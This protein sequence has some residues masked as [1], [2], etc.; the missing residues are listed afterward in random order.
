MRIS[1]STRLD[2]IILVCAAYAL[3]GAMLTM[4]GW[5]LN[6]PG[7]TDWDGDGINMKPNASLA[8]LFAAAGLLLCLL[9]PGA[10]RLIRFLAAVPLCIGTLT[11]FQHL[12]GI[13]LGI[14]TLL[15]WEPHGMRA[16][17][18]PGRMGPPMSTATLLLG[19]GIAVFP[20][21]RRIRSYRLVLGCGLTVTLIS[22]IALTG[23]LF[24]ADPLFAI[25]QLTAI[26]FQAA[27]MILAMGVALVL[28]PPVGPRPLLTE[29]SATGAFVRW[30]FPLAFLIPLG[31]G[32]L[33][34]ATEAVN[35]L[36]DDFG[37]ALRTVA[38]MF[39]LIAI[40]W[41]GG[42][43]LLRKDAA[44]RRS[45]RELADFFENATIALHW[46]SAD[47]TI[48]KA[49]QAELDLTGFAHDEYIGRN[50]R[51][52]HVDSERAEHI[53]SVLGD[54]KGLC[55]YPS[56]L[57][58]KDG[59]VRDVLVDSSAYMVE[60]RFVHSRC[61]TTDVTE[62][63]AAERAQ[64]RLAAIVED[65][66]D[67]IISI[68]LEGE[69][70]SWNAGAER[71][72]GYTAAEA[73]GRT[74]DLLIPANVRGEERSILDQLRRGNRI[75]HFET[76]R[77]HKEG[78]RINVSL[79]VSPL[80]DLSGRLVGASKIARD[81]SERKQA[82]ARIMAEKERVQILADAVP[83]LIS[84][85]DLDFRHVLVN[86]AYEK[87]FRKPRIAFVGRTLREVLGDKA[88]EVIRPHVQT[89]LGGRV[90]HFESEIEFANQPP[91]WIDATY[92]P[93]LDMAG[94]VRGFVA[95][96]MDITARKRAEGAI[97]TLVE[98]A[99]FG[100]YIV[101]SR[102]RIVMLNAG[103]QARA[104]RNVNPAVGRD[105]GEAIRVLWPPPVAED[106]IRIFRHTL[107]TGEP[108]VSKDYVQPRAD[109][110][111]VES[112]E[113]E[114]HRIVLP[115]GQYGV[116]CYYFESTQLRRAEQALRDSD[117]RKDE[118]IAILAHELRNPLAPLRNLL[119]YLRRDPPGRASHREAIETM[120][121]QLEQMVRIIDDL[122][123]V[124]RIRQGKIELRREPCDLTRILSVAAE[125][126]QPA[127]QYQGHRAAMDLPAEPVI[128]LGDPVRLTQVFANLL[129]N[130]CKYTPP[131]GTISLIVRCDGPNVTVAVQ[132][133]GVG[134]PLDKLD[135][136]FE[137]FAQIDQSLERSR[138]GLGIGLTLAKRLVDLHGGSISAFSEG[139]GRGS[140]FTVQLPVLLDAS[141]K[142]P[143]PATNGSPSAVAQRRIL[144]VDDNED[145]ARSMAMIMRLDGHETQIAFDGIEAFESA[146]TFRP[147]VALLDIGLPQMNGYDLCRKIRDE[148]WGRGMVVIALTG[149]GQEGDRK[150]S[151]DAG[152]DAHL[153]KPVDPSELSRV[154][155]ELL[156][157][158]PE[159]SGGVL[160]N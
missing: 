133:T 105:F 73:V 160:Q 113:W 129:N 37:T 66:D 17:A 148:V 103:S 15:F 121:R 84:Y 22:L 85:I 64:L 145:S 136:I 50:V 59:T 78:R 26:S 126:A 39:L 108:Y 74:V 77:L 68:S 49:N 118:F 144:V 119:A 142:P 154:L 125:S 61:F 45:E 13:D 31:L 62:R 83:A 93:D 86:E 82:E 67:A 20:R 12:T 8:V 158:A 132:D 98:Q 7:L 27:S 47:G 106:I 94:S 75:E 123:D 134:I 71:L 131:G 5:C 153:V 141:P 95:H 137:L 88:W 89:A 34:E 38:E 111:E 104:F 32:L 41:W 40:V 36:D 122:L 4:A 99:P 139:P 97:E 33:K 107:A 150:Q 29:S 130:A 19:A 90:V 70:L 155:G 63:L 48:L 112:Y 117:R 76:V 42:R 92:T 80:R 28:L 21:A 6:I 14:D 52:I 87:W 69:I 100:L 143:P 157:P 51:D 116:V 147:D 102:F 114:L 128:V 127:L 140:R 23:Y 79:T 30:A 24:D 159:S 101:D 1:L 44:V 109:I 151:R 146:R 11:L 156:K 124:N 25:T 81:I 18:A 65:S 115:D 54:G 91:R 149:W 138:G 55:Q 9:R 96:V 2:A 16:T 56:R 58:R 43:M 46:V 3:T 53:L 120:D 72:Y 152:F 60:G 10:T 35:L 135:R 57:R 110:D